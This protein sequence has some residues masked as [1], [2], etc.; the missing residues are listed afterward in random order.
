MV[1]Q[2][3][4]FSPSQCQYWSDLVLKSASMWRR[5][6]RAIDFFTLGAAQY[7][8]GNVNGE[9]TEL[10][11]DRLTKINPYLKENFGDLYLHLV[12]YFDREFQYKCC[13]HDN[14][15]RPGF[16]VFGARPNHS[17]SLFNS[18]YFTK[19]GTLHKHYT[20]ACLAQLLELPSSQLPEHLYSVTIPIKLP[21]LGSGLNI[22]PDGVG[23]KDPVYVPY[24]EG[25]A[26]GFSGDLVH[27]IAPFSPGTNYNKDSYR[28]TL[29]VH[30]LPVGSECFLFF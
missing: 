28:I 24:R 12:E 10:Y 23:S 30:L 27:Q 17:E 21:E 2:F 22:W 15:A 26:Y 9:S 1:H 6:A 5:R 11:L 29:Q 4:I 16:H 19:G 3:K 7:L 18:A 14:L 25:Y 8:D 20:P 13:F